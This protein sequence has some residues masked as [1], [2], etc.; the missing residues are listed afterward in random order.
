[1]AG[2]GVAWQQPAKILPI[3]PT[4]ADVILRMERSFEATL[5]ALENDVAHLPSRV[6]SLLWV[7]ASLP[8]MAEYGEHIAAEADVL[9]ELNARLPSLRHGA[10]HLAAAS[11]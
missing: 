10:A 11:A 3:D 2:T 8:I 5:H 6:R 4:V 9:A 1:V 7:L